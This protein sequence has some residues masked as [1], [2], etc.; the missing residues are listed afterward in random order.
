MRQH[1]A[2]RLWH[3]IAPQPPLEVYRRGAELT[4]LFIF[5][6]ITGPFMSLLVPPSPPPPSQLAIEAGVDI[7]PVYQFGVNKLYN[8][9]R[10]LRG[11]RAR[12]AQKLALPMIIWWGRFG[13]NQPLDDSPVN[14]VIGTPFPASQYTLD[15]IDKVSACVRQRRW[16]ERHCEERRILSAIW[17]DLLHSAVCTLLSS[18]RPCSPPLQ[19]HAD[20]CTCLKNLYDTYKDQFGQ[21]DMPLVFVGKDFQ[22]RDV[23]PQVFR[24][25]GVHTSH[26]IPNTVH[27]RVE[28]REIAEKRRRETQLKLDAIE[29]ERE[30]LL[31]QS[32]GQGD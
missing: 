12:L 16:Q 10:G 28:L 26:A 21:G 25:L 23:V 14:T 29:A 31:A 24:R 20:Y 15:E 4:S 19:A 22:D 13:T 18:D 1:A 30:R 9:P 11:L 5:L 6:R 17:S 27:H 8:T 3:A 7:V 2:I 32:E